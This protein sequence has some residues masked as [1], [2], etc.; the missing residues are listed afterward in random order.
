MQIA[1]RIRQVRLQ[2]A[3]SLADLALRT[4]LSTS[5]LA[6]Y[7]DGRDVPTLETLDRFAATMDVPVQAFFY[8]DTDSKLTPWLTA[9]PTLPEL[10]GHPSCTRRTVAA[11]FFQS[12][13]LRAAVTFLRLFINGTSRR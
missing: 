10:S 13:R 4:G 3:L 7:E 2:Y 9:R 6:R 12:R 1:T 11:S 8:G 5:L